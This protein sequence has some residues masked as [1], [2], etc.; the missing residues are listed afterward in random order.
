VSRP[1]TNPAFSQVS[2]P[3]ADLGA[4]RNVCEQL[5]Q[6]VDSIGGFRGDPLGLGRAVTF[7]D[8]IDMGVIDRLIATS[9]DGSATP[10]DGA[11]YNPTDPTGT[12]IASPGVMMGLK[13]SFAPRRTG[14]LFVAISGVVA[15]DTSGDSM[16][17]QMLVGAGIPPNNGAGVVGEAAVRAQNIGPVSAINQRLSFCTQAIIFG[18]T[19]NSEY[20]FDLRLAAIVGGTASLHAVSVSIV[21]L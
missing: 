2:H 16:E 19:I 17:L 9:P 6:N 7:Q 20:W 10:P 13:A 18:L 12:A 8:L 11:Q 4:L 14:A 1:G 15:N 21:E 5:K 3:I